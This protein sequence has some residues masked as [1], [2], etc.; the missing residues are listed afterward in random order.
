MNAHRSAAPTFEYIK[1]D[2]CCVPKSRAV[3]V[4]LYGTDRCHGTQFCKI[5]FETREVEYVFRNLNTDMQAVESLQ[6]IYAPSLAR[7]PTVVVGAE[8]LDNPSLSELD[9]ALERQS[10][11]PLKLYQC[12]EQMRY[13]MYLPEGEA[14][15]SY[16][17]K[18]GI[19]CLDHTFVPAQS[20]KSGVGKQ[21][22]VETLK[23]LCRDGQKTRISCQFIECIARRTR[24]EA[25]AY[26]HNLAS[27]DIWQ[28][29]E[30]ALEWEYI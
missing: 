15:I 29:S 4:E 27:A 18:D 25:T 11:M 7:F 14:F 22:V 8:I 20:R 19:R 12:V 30:S 13:F 26:L 1:S 6:A 10:V 23:R 28:S 5:V 16:R 9:R 3:V 17:D 21:L 2:A 24:D